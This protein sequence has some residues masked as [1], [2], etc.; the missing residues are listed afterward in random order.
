MILYNTKNWSATFF[1]ISIFFR[2]SYNHKALLISQLLIIS[3]ASLI[4]WLNLEVPSLGFKFGI[5][6]IFFSMIGLI[7]SLF[8]VFRVNTAYAK[9]WEGRQQWGA[10]VNVCRSLASHMDI[11]LPTSDREMRAYYASQ[12]ANFPLVLKLHLREQALPEGDLGLP[13]QELAELK[14]ALHKPMC[15][16]NQLTRGIHQM[17]R[18]EEMDGFDKRT[19]K[20][21]I[22]SLINILGACERIKNTPIPFSHADFV[23][24]LILI[25]GLALP[26]GLMD[27]FGY[28]TIPAAAL[29][30]YAL[31]GLEMISEE[32]ENPFGED[33][34]DLPLSTLANTIC[35]NVHEVLAVPFE[36]APTP[37]L[38]QRALKVID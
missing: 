34:N 21:L 3:Y 29:I 11:L 10:L 14:D 12:I 32:I 17:A 24:R 1:K 35:L 9:W 27:S 8:L 19:L 20:E 13:E 15:T 4:T 18:N 22:D 30:F 6:P 26:F 16:A 25:Y 38:P 36:P 5:D 31:V 28:M 2:N 23:K 33:N 7:L 37:D